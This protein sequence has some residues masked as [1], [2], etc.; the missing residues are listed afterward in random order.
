MNK[1]ASKVILTFD[2]NASATLTATQKQQILEKLA[3]RINKKG[4][5]QFSNDSVGVYGMSNLQNIL[6]LWYCHTLRL[7]LSLPR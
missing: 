4:I 7:A 3:N 5:L 1:V 2:L 6:Y